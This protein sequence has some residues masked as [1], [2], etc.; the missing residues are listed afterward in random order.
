MNQIKIFVAVI[1]F[2]I[3]ISASAQTSNVFKDCPDCPE[4]VVIPSGNF[5][6]GSP[7][8]ESGRF[9][10]ESPRHHV[11][12]KKFSIGQ[13]EVTVGEFHHF[14]QA[15]QYKTDAERNVGNL[16]G[17]KTW[18][19]SDGIFAW[20]A[21]QYWNNPGF[22]QTDRQPVVCISWND[23][24]AFVKW[25]TH[26]TGKNYRLPSEAEWEYAA[27]GN[28]STARYWENSP[29]SACLYA[30]VA[31]TTKGPADMQWKNKH[32]CEDEY[33]FTAPVRSYLPN[34]FGLYDMIGNVW[35]WTEDSF[36][37]DYKGAPSDGSSWQGNDMKRVFR[38]GSWNNDPR[39]ARAATR[40]FG[41]PAFR[42]SSVGFRVVRTLP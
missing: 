19:A 29:K 42:I 22:G 8:D 5:I 39:S 15:T 12:V 9:D 2:S 16:P 35:E 3:T 25:L 32:E 6:M 21:G 33:F 28:T 24:I 17:C 36:H 34:A 13:N 20:R 23:A 38:G 10:N 41:G 1:L 18:D 37:D 31:D 26:E 30:N 11:S 40:D 14:V 27:R 4:M 7:E